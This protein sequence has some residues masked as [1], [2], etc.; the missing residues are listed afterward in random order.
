MPVDA[1]IEHGVKPGYDL[2]D[3]TGLLVKSL[4]ITPT[5]EKI[6]RKGNNRKVSYVRYENPLLN[7]AFSGAILPDGAGAAVGFA[8]QHPGTTITALANYTGDIHGF[9]PADGKIIYEDPVRSLS[10][11]DEEP[12]VSF[13]AV[14]YPGIAAE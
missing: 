5:R 3:E 2:V 13:T 8:N 10:D 12:Q 14:Q 7:L 4:E 6:Q 9:S 1:I 11:G